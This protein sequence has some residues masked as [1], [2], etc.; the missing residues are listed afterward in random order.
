[1]NDRVPRRE[2]LWRLILPSAAW[3]GTAGW[4]QSTKP[5]RGEPTLEPARADTNA[6]RRFSVKDF[7]AMGDGMT[8]DTEAIQAAINALYTKIGG[9]GSF[10]NVSGTL[11]F[12]RG[13]YLVGTLRFANSPTS[14]AG[15][16]IVLGE[17]MNATILVLKPGTNGPLFDCGDA[18]IGN[19]LV[20]TTFRDLLLDG[21]KANQTVAAPLLRCRR[22]D[23][24]IYKNLIVANSSGDGWL[25]NNSSI[26]LSG[27]EVFTCNGNGITVQD[28]DSVVIADGYVNN[29]LGYGLYAQFINSGGIIADQGE[30]SLVLRGNHFEQ[31]HLGEIFL[32]D[33]D[34]VDIHENLINGYAASSIISPTVN[35]AGGS[36]WARI[37]NNFFDNANDI[38]TY[39]D[40]TGSEEGT[41]AIQFGAQTAECVWGNN[42]SRSVNCKIGRAGAQ[43]VK[44]LKTVDLGRNYAIDP[45]AFKPQAIVQNEGGHTHAGWQAVARTNLLLWSEDLSNAVWVRT[46]LAAVN[47]VVSAIGT[48][49]DPVG[50]GSQV[51]AT[52]STVTSL[53]QNVTCLS[54]VAGDLYTFSVWISTVGVVSDRDVRM[55]LYDSIGN[56]LARKVWV[57]NTGWQRVSVGFVA[58]GNY[59]QINC[60]ITNAAFVPDYTLYLWGAQ[61]NKGDLAPYLRTT[62]E[63]ATRNPGFV[64]M[65]VHATRALSIG[66]GSEIVGHLSGTITWDPPKTADGAIA[67][68]TVRVTGAACGDTVAVGFSTAVP[69]GALLAGAVTAADAVTVTLFNKT[70]KTLDLSPGT[71][72]A[73]VWKH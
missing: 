31:S 28:S 69:A 49:Y 33:Y 20:T 48:P 61:L 14:T 47:Q 44:A 2:A 40:G 38:A 16:A 13:Q 56:C 39:D 19:E 57:F 72:R 8:D 37:T 59:S 36:R 60:R 25:I 1:M 53:Q 12:P 24:C 70:G 9:A 23:R 11:F 46:N 6:P 58:A 65:G 26:L 7:G 41:V 55:E 64:G 45:L 22:C 51:V 52:A 32:Q 35:V 66:L 73:D 27:C 62:S 15:G 68:T 21:N 17:G 42:A 5:L 3:A 10:P 43:V 30:C 4:K 63:V 50:T 18:V 67:S 54:I 29:H 34:N 71:L